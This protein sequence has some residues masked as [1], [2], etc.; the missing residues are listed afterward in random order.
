MN[1][2]DKVALSNAPQLYLS[3]PE[4][5]DKSGAGLFVLS[6]NNL[7]PA[8]QPIIFGNTASFVMDDTKTVDI[9]GNPLFFNDT[10]S[11]ECVVFAGRPVEDI[12]IIID[13]DSQNALYITPDGFTIKLFFDNALSTYAQIAT[14][15]IKDWSKKFYVVLTISS[16]QATLSINGES[17]I[18][19]YQDTI[20]NS[21]NLT[22]GGGSTDYSYLIDGIGFYNNTITNKAR[23]IN[24]PLPSHSN[25][26]ASKYNGKTTRFDGYTAGKSTTFTL[27]DFLYDNG[28]YTLI[29]YSAYIQDGLDY[30]IV[31][32]NDERVTVS[33][34]I[35]LDDAGEFN[36]YLLVGTVSDTTLRFMVNDVDVESDFILT[37]Q[38]VANGDIFYETPA[39]LILSGLALYGS[40]DESIV[41][42]PDGTKLPGAAYLGTWVYSDVI[43]ATPQTVEI[44][45][46]PIDSGSDTVVFASSDGS[47]SFGPTGAITGFT[48]YL[49][50][51]L[52]TDF[53]D[54]KYDQWNHL[55]LVDSGAAATEFYLNST[56]GLG[57]DDTISYMLL[58]AYP[59]DLTA[60]DA[61]FLYNIV[62]GLNKLTAS[63]SASISEGTFPGGSGFNAYSYPWAILG[64]GG[65]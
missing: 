34:D 12:P 37:I 60:D 17:V 63:E 46:K 19:S 4:I 40:V 53:T 16:T 22:L 1:D 6:N 58:T 15:S 38:P 13:D 48:A 65:S 24:D 5:T 47:A 42:T 41:N 11:F 32:T 49:N 7:T 43:T 59:E 21:T 39:D 45:F 8:G 33:Y 27:N 3:A 51:Q 18:L 10:A 14:V 44:V 23:Y 29:Y 20:I 50:G 36:E 2:Y 28:I 30:L 31:R 64:A 35:D 26:A 9:T 25:Y 54:L 52:V 55:V 62:A 61:E 56:D 57:S